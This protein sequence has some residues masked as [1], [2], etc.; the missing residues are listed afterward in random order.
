MIYDFH[1][2]LG[3]G[4]IASRTGRTEEAIN[5]LTLAGK[6]KPENTRVLLWLAAS[7]ESVKQ[8]RQFLERALQ[9][10]PSLIPAQA[11][12]DRLNNGIA[13]TIER[14]SD[15]F[16]IFTCPNCGGKQRFDPD[17]LGLVCAYCQQVEHL[18][19]A[20]AAQTDSH[21]D[22]EII[23][24]SGNW[25]IWNSEFSCKACGAKLSIPSDQSTTTCPFCDADQVTL[26]TAAPDLITPTAIVP[27]QLHADDVRHIMT[28]SRILRRLGPDPSLTPV[29]LPFWAFDARV[30]IRCMLGYRIPA[31]VF[32]E[33]DRVFVQD[34]WPQ[35][36]SW[37][38]CDIGNL[39]IY[40][41]HARFASLVSEILPFDLK[42][43]LEYRPEMLAGWQAELYQVALDDASTE[44]LQKIR[45]LAFRSATKRRLFMREA[46]MLADD[47]R[48]FDRTYKLILLPV[49]ILRYNLKGKTYRVMI[50]GQTGKGP[51]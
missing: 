9:I 18:H 33:S 26:Q 4:I 44:A 11:L 22:A 45:T 28:K 17:L 35:N 51:D 24:R 21:L 32:S 1:E 31:E 25:A 6:I 30:H 43:A 20:H 14:S 41:G 8:E 5:Y 49:W 19:S 38:E 47:V 50:N 10:N 13:K 16:A 46:D 42:S 48:V 3:R 34:N 2:L 12:L 40:A 37:Y 23:E 39:L 7:A 29:Y 36:T 27:L 15:A